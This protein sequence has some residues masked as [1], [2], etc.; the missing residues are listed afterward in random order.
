M[1]H[2]LSFSPRRFFAAL[3]AALVLLTGLPAAAQN[4]FAPVVTVN[5]RVV[6]RYEL[7]QRMAFLRLLRAP[8]DV[9]ELALSQLIDER[10]Q[11]DTARR[12]GV[13]LS[14]AEL[15]TGMAEFAARHC[16]NTW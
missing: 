14:D 7:S 9:R 10:L 5:D 2:F 16:L 1:N 3:M 12:Y 6:S 8:G 11:L 13:E 15:E 4:L